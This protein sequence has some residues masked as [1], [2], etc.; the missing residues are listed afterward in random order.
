MPAPAEAFEYAAFISYSHADQEWVRGWLAPTLRD[1]GLRVCVDYDSFPIGR[2]IVAAIEHAVVASRKTLMVLT[3]AYLD[4]DWGAF[5]NIL[6]QTLDPNAQQLRLLPILHIACEP[7]LRIR[8]LNGVDLQ[9]PDA[10]A[11]ARL[12]AAIKEEAPPPAPERAPVWPAPAQP[13]KAAAVELCIEFGPPSSRGATFPVT[14]RFPA[15]GANAGPFKFTPPLDAKVLT[16][17]YWYLEVY[18]SW[19]TEID[20]QRARLVE[21]SLRNWGRK[22]FRKVF[23]D[24]DA[25]TLFNEFKRAPAGAHLLTVDIAFKVDD[26]DEKEQARLKQAV[27]DLA[28]LPWELLADEGGHLFNLKPPITVR[29]RLQKTNAPVERPRQL[30]VRVLM[31]VSRPED[32]TFIDPRTIAAPLLDALETLGNSVEVEFL[33]PPTLA[34]LQSRLDDESLPPVDILHFDGHGVYRHDTGLGY[35]LF[36]DSQHGS[37]RVNADQLGTLLNQ[38]GVAV[39][40]LNACQSAK[41]EETNPFGS[42]AS[43]LVEAGI[44]SVVAMNY[45]LLVSTA[46]RLAAV[47]YGNLAAGLTVGQALDSARR[48]LL[49]DT[50]R[51]SIL[52]DGKEIAFHL[53]DWFLPAL[54]QQTSDPAPFRGASPLASPSPAHGRGGWGVRAPSRFTTCSQVAPPSTQRLATATGSSS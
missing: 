34:A 5:E 13:E 53:T 44:G 51:G 29:R 19:P 43:R 33:R 17:L 6:V 3:P 7:P 15:Q 49:S 8:A 22:L 31:A 1:A 21:A 9:Q 38:R 30:P 36:E 11:V 47:L 20:D 25:R 2:P 46:E 45:S 50:V 18:P 54:Y 10:T 27:H 39:V 24:G 26:D 23:G 14:I 32:A 48:K 40:I 35:L 52:R 28:G 12:V 41:A 37:D 16:D 42:V 4:S